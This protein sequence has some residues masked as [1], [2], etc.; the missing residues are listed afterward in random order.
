MKTIAILAVLVGL[1][2]LLNTLGAAV[3][4]GRGATSGTTLVLFIATITVAAA[5]VASGVALLARGRRA[6]N[7]ARG[8]AL[9]CLVLFAILA[10]VRPGFSI[11]AMLLGIAFPIVMLLVIRRSTQGST[12]AAG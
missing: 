10:A 11:A 1:L 5:L 9:A 6:I 8:A 2:E 7:F 3:G 4:A 12:P